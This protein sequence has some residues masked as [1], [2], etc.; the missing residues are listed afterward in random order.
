[1]ISTLKTPPDA[2]LTTSPCVNI[3]QQW[4]CRRLG[5]RATPPP[6]KFQPVG[7]FSSKNTKFGAENPLCMGKIKILSTNNLLCWK[8]ATS[9]PTFLTDDDDAAPQLSIVA[10]LLLLLPCHYC[11]YYFCCSDENDRAFVVKYVEAPSCGGPGQLPTLP[12]S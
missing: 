12:I 7:K 6:A 9:C 11:Y 3:P 4:R 10:T 1:M 2:D 5:S 8:I